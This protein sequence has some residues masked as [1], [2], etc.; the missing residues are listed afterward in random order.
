MVICCFFALLAAL[1]G[2]ALM[3]RMPVGWVRQT[4]CDSRCAAGA[5]RLVGTAVAT[6]VIT[7]SGLS[8]VLAAHLASHDASMF[9]VGPICSTVTGLTSNR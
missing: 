4:Y 2:A 1:P 5:D 6:A 8:V 3:R 9:A 7:I